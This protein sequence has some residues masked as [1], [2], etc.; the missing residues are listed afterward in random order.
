[1]KRWFRGGRIEESS[2]PLIW[3]FIVLLSLHLTMLTTEMLLG[4]VPV[5][6]FSAATFSSMVVPRRVSLP[7]SSARTYRYMAST[8]RGP[9][10]D[11]RSHTTRM[12][13]GEGKEIVENGG[14]EE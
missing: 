14:G 12:E 1:M 5:S 3:D 9:P 13:D 10:R 11:A 6:L 2:R 4:G 8:S 7:P